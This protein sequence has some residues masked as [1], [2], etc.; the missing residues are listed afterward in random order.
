MNWQTGISLYP[1]L[2]YSLEEQLKSIDL[3]GAHGIN[4]LF[5]SL[6]LA[7]Q[8]TELRPELTRIID[9]ARSYG[10]SVT[11]DISPQTT[12]IIGSALTGKALRDFG[13]DGIRIDFGFSVDESAELAEDGDL[14]LEVNAST[15]T[16][17][18]LISLIETGFPKE[19]LLGCHNF[20][21]RPET[22][23]SRELFALRSKAFRE[24][25]IPVHAF[26]PSFQRPRA[27]LGKGLPTLEHH[28]CLSTRTAAKELAYSGLVDGIRFGDPLPDHEEIL[29]ISA[30]HPSYMEFRIQLEEGLSEEEIALLSRPHTNRLDPAAKAIRSQEARAALVGSIAPRNAQLRTKGTITIDNENYGPYQGELQIL[31]DEQPADSDVNV[32]ARIIPE[33]LTLLEW[34]TPGKMFS[35]QPIPPADKGEN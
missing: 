16:W 32:A 3:A 20:Y 21:P 9:H 19:K 35:F 28:R 12:K 2:G 7:G 30:V 23:L 11:A 27:P 13:L 33:E 24:Q 4:N 26:L 31:R 34:L 14:R 17:E 15:M 25:G 29:A 10:M 8:E 18:Q 5:T 1:G 6:H 22:G